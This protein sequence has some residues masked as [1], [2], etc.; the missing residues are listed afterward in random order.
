[1]SLEARI[2]ADRGRTAEAEDI[3]KRL[4]GEEASESR[5]AYTMAYV[6]V[7]CGLPGAED[8]L[9]QYVAVAP[10]DPDLVALLS[11]PAPGGGTWRE[12]LEVA[13]PDPED[14]T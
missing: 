3:L 9:R 6:R 7:Q 2:L 13:P 5:W 8:S 1:M 4:A 11:R 10:E 14:A 12:R